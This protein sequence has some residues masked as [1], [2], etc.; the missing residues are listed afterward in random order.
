MAASY[1]S[2]IEWMALNDDTEW[3]KDGEPDCGLSVTAAL[4]A[5]LFGKTDEKVKRDLARAVAKM[6]Q[7]QQR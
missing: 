1:R 4:V 3:V 7:E 2:A 6:K 5:D